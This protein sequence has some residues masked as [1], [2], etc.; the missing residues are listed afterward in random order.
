MRGGETK[1]EGNPKSRAQRG[2]RPR[3]QPCSEHTECEHRTLFESYS[4][5]GSFPGGSVVKNLP[6][7]QETGVQSL[8]GEE[9]LEKEMATP[10]SIS[11]KTS[12]SSRHRYIASAFQKRGL[13]L[14]MIP[15]CSP[16]GETLGG[17]LGH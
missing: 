12:N 3:P 14:L 15:F 9:P 5:F 2:V 10:S 7:R 16:A 17:D 13:A 1:E 4:T 8:G 11:L 6:T